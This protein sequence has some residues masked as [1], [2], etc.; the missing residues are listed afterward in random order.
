V[1][2]SNGPPRQLVLDLAHAPSR[3]RDDF[4]EAPCNAGGL[5]IVERWPDWPAYASLLIGPEGAG[6]THLGTIWAE[7]A[8]AR[9]VDAATLSTI[10]PRELMGRHLFLDDADAAAGVRE[11]KLFHLLNAATEHGTSVLLAARTLPRAWG[12]ALPDLA[13]RLAALPLVEIGL[14]DEALIRAV[15]VKQFADRQIDVPQEVVAFLLPRM[16]RSFS[17]LATL[18][19]R[20]DRLALAERRPVTRAV[21]A[22][23]LGLDGAS[24]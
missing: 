10:D 13:S 21:A 9:T 6:K 19:A 4:V 1:S 18:V 20:V 16:E 8:D 12:V 23:A 22:R 24:S 7:R 15:M 14:P 5:A 11:T 2:R 17:A 3:A